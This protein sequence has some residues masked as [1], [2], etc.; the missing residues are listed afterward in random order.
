[1][2]AFRKEERRTRGLDA[3]AATV[4]TGATLVALDAAWLGGIAAPLYKESLAPLMRPTPFWPAVA[5]FYAFYAITVARFAVLGSRGR[6]D[7]LRRGA[8]LGLVVYAAY[9][10]TNWG[11][12]RGW[13]ARLVPIDLAWGVVLTAA[14]ALAGRMALDRLTS[15]RSEAERM[16]S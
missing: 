1:M 5:F 4:A 2:H 6:G 16:S 9:E 10:L 12:L 8:Q 13:P 15:S 3:F 7:A 14:A 11:V